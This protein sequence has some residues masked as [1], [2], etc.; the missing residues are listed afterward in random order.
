MTGRFWFDAK[1]KILKGL[2]KGGE[3]MME[4]GPDGKVR[5]TWLNLKASRMT[6]AEDFFVARI[7]GFTAL[8]P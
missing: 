2:E 1:E 3:K 4:F 5:A 7:G 6:S 8:R